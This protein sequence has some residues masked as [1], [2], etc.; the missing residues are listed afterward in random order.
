MLGWPR[1]FIRLVPGLLIASFLLIVLAA[2]A[3]AD[4]PRRVEMQDKCDP[5]TFNAA[6]GPGTCVGD[7]DVT[8]QEFLDELIEDQE[9]GSWRFAPDKMGLKRGEQ[10]VAT[11]TGGEVH[12]FTCVTK[13]GGG[14]VPEINA[15]IGDPAPAVLC[16]GRSFANLTPDDFIAPAMSTMPMDLQPGTHK[17]E[18]LIHPWMRTTVTVEHAR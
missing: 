16:G 2:Q 1:L 6:I 4:S 12:T 9:V 5:A 10:V 8:F 17:F 14:I 15:L 3:E 13:F 7:G 11:N 18:C